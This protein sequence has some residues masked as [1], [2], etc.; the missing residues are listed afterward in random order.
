MSTNSQRSFTAGLYKGI[1][2]GYKDGHIDGLVAGAAAVVA[3]P[4]LILTAQ[5]GLRVF[6]RKVSKLR[7]K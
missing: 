6:E 7:R 1:E 2:Q 3:L 4:L 5:R